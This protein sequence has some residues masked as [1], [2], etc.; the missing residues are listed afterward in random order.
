MYVGSKNLKYDNCNGVMERKWPGPG[1]VVDRISNAQAEKLLNHPD[2]FVDVTGKSDEEI[3]RLASAAVA[4]V[5][6]R[7]RKGR[8][9]THSG[10]VLLE[11][12]SDDELLAEVARRK[13]QAGAIDA[14]PETPAPK[15]A[16]GPSTHDLHDAQVIE[17]KVA[18][19]MEV[20]VERDNPDDFDENG[21]PTLDAIVGVIGF[22]ISEDEYLRALDVD[23]EAPEV[24]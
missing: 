23:S 19:A 1:T 8:A 10:G 4:K 11:F 2:E 14:A 7:K 5:A 15:V 16:E 21:R 22:S 9:S 18:H 3:Q 20:I 6:E 17:E 13:L 12:C 24:A